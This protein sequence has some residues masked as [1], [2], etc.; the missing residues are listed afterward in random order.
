MTGVSA[1]NVTLLETC[2]GK[3]GAKM[4]M[5][6]HAGTHIQT[7]TPCSIHPLSVYRM[8]LGVKLQGDLLG[9]LTI[10]LI[11]ISYYI[12]YIVHYFM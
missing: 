6:M 2:A 1:R 4:K 5:D 10:L 8:K 3:S 7:N 12:H 9:I 11:Y